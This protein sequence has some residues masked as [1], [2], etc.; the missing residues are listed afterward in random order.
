[1][2]SIFDLTVPE[3]TTLH[4]AL[5]NMSDAESEIIIKSLCKWANANGYPKN[6]G[7]K[8]I[9]NLLQESFLDEQSLVEILEI[10]H[11]D[12][13]LIKKSNLN[14][15]EIK[16][17]NKCTEYLLKG[18]LIEDDYLPDFLGHSI[19]KGKMARDILN[20]YKRHFN[21]NLNKVEK[22]LDRILD[23]QDISSIRSQL[24]I[25][26]YNMWATWSETKGSND[27][28][29]FRQTENPN[30]VRLCLALDPR[31]RL[32]PIYLL[33]YRRELPLYR[34]TVA[35]AFFNPYFT[36]TSPDNKKYGLTDPNNDDLQS[37]LEQYLPDSG[38]ACVA[39]PEGLHEPIEFKSILVKNKGK[40]ILLSI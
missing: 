19:D 8:F 37:C 39:R 29:D 2:F 4:K 5:L 6:K 7:R 1:M 27:P 32:D 21:N 30:E 28:F 13:K 34:P 16:L 15:F 23:A 10:F 12:S 25:R 31:S 40:M 11:I 26:K 36:A 9:L 22:F 20:T 38:Y 33:T 17:F 35:D 14:F 24:K 18:G 3:N